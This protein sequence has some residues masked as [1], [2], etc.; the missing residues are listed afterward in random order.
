MDRSIYFVQRKWIVIQPVMWLIEQVVENRGLV[1]VSVCEC[2]PQLN[3]VVRRKRSNIVALA[4]VDS[5]CVE[6]L[7][8]K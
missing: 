2:S 7:Q 5:I 4:A 1:F 6:P 3:K 8:V